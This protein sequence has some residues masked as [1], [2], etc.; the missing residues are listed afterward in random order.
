MSSKPHI[1]RPTLRPVA[2]YTLPEGLEWEFVEA[3]SYANRP[4]LPSSR[5]PF[6]VIAVDR[7]LTADECDRFG[8]VPTE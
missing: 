2:S 3:P 1:Y 6:G 5:H 8:M 4:D 7:K